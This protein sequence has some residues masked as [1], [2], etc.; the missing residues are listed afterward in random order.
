M[1]VTQIEALSGKVLCTIKNFSKLN[2]GH[3]SDISIV[4]DCKWKVQIYPKGNNAPDQLSLYLVVADKERLPNGWSRD[5]K[6]SLSVIDQL[7][8][9]STVKS[10]KHKFDAKVWY[11]GL[12]DF[13]TLAELHDPVRGYIV[14]DTCV[15]EVEFTA[16]PAVPKNQVASLMS[17]RTDVKEYPT[18]YAFFVEMPGLKLSDIKVQLVDNHKALLVSGD[19]EKVEEEK[20]VEYVSTERIGNLSRKFV[21]SEDMNTDE[22]SATYK[23]GVVT[24]T[25]DKLEANKSPKTIEV[26]LA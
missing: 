1:A 2:S 4:S 12:S 8:N 19:Q 23:D 14:N 25:I 17:I 21:I 22:I 18:A 11:G 26:K 9:M 5:L 7:N 13:M 6:Y 16:P 3:S 10:F 24:V 20:G 15:V